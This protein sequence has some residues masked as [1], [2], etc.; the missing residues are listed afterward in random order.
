MARF[1]E[2]VSLLLVVPALL[3][4]AFGATADSILSLVSKNTS[5]LL[6]LS[7]RVL[8]SLSGALAHCLTSVSLSAG[9]GSSINVSEGKAG[10]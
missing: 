3:P 6:F 9:L 4:V 7:Q 10:P 8:L 2:A 5:S 1:W